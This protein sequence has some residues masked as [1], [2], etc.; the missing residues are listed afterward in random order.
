MSAC[1]IVLAPLGLVFFLVVSGQTRCAAASAPPKPNFVLVLVDDLG[2]ADVGCF[3]SRYYETP[4]IDRLATQGMRFTDAYAAAAV[5]SPT[6]ASILTGKHPAR[7]H[8]TDFIPGEGDGAGNKLR[9]PQWQMS[10][11][12]EE[13]TIAEALKP[14][15]YVSASIG[16]WHL[17]GPASF[18]EH[19][20]FDVDVAASPWGQPASYFWPYEGPTRTVTGLRAGGH[21][22]EY[23]TDRLT[24]E[25]EAFIANNR[26]RPFFLYLAHYAVHVP[27]QAKAGLV[28]K[29]R[30]KAPHDGQANP[31]YGAMIESVD[32]S[33]GRILAQ[34]DGLGIADRT[35]VIFMSDNGGL[36]VDGTTSNAPWRGGKGFPY[37]GGLRI[38]LIVKWPGRTAAG[39]TCHTPVSSMDI[40]PTLL[41][42]AGVAPP[43]GVDGESLVP[44]LTQR[45]SFAE[46]PLYW[47]Y[48]HYWHGQAVRPFG[49][50][51]A[52]AWKAI[53]FYEDMRIELYNLD[54]DPGE[55]HD[56]A[57]DNPS[58]ATE[59]RDA[60]H[61]WRASVGAQMPQPE[62]GAP[63]GPTGSY[64]PAPGSKASP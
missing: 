33:V 34:L 35:V 60:L 15:G 4:N 27:L 5:C 14:A 58:R 7:L 20:G 36:S 37:E 46:R 13:T 42:I 59:L 38:P 23:L 26:D 50:V 1:R 22:G 54:D 55:T 63:A 9:V 17:G 31:T 53:E 30:G 10:L 64:P 25:A 61:G 51:R 56:L 16:K 2:W 39:S 6:R 29:Y 49:A 62:P 41:A 48:P 52:G 44:L 21:P 32:D 43:P 8:L 12:L 40:L 47:H 19:Q 24:T 3:G 11:P 28:E 18:P 45:G 57:R